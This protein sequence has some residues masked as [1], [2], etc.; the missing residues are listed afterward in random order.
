MFTFASLGGRII[1]MCFDSEKLR[2]Q[3][4]RRFSECS[5]NEMADHTE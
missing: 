1:S 4:R 5:N 2:R 3:S